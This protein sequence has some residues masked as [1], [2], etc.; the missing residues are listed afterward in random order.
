MYIYILIGEIIAK[1]IR[2][3]ILKI[4]NNVYRKGERFVILKMNGISSTEILL[5]VNNRK[6]SNFSRHL[7]TFPPSLFNYLE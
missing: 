6:F 4:L 5:V 3:S 1:Q 2:F 7:E